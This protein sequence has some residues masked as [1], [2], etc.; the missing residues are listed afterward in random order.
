MEVCGSYS[1][2]LCKQN[3][4]SELPKLTGSTCELMS[5]TLLRSTIQSH[6]KFFF[7]KGESKLAILVLMSSGQ[8]NLQVSKARIK[9]QTCY[10]T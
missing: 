9:C 5:S 1:W 3:Q 2:G 7:K 6:L 8:F 4:R 10:I